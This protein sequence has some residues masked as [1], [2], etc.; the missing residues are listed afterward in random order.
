MK[1]AVIGT[2]GFGYAVAYALSKNN[3]DIIMWSEDANKVRR[4]KGGDR[5]IIPGFEIMPGIDVTDSMEEAL[6]NTE[7]IFIV[8]PSQFMASVCK[9]MKPFVKPNMHF[10]GTENEILSTAARLPN[11]FD[12]PLIS[13]TF[14]TNR[15]LCPRQNKLP[16]R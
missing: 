2:G 7:I 4:F 16:G 9:Q 8:V 14:I 15:L 6:N 12:T 1:V 10:S 11:L 13:S 5:N 3:N